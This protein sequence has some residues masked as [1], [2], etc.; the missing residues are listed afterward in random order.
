MCVC[1]RHYSEV[2]DLGLNTLN[3]TIKYF[4]QDPLVFRSSF[5]FNFEAF[6][7]YLESR[8]VILVLMSK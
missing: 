6:E 4:S 3:F 1:F 8:N 2:L 7:H 5:F